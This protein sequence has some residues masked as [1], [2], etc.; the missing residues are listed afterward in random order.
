M[1]FGFSWR[2]K[3]T[4][5]ASKE[6]VDQE[7]DDRDEE[8]AKRSKLAYETTRKREFKERWKKDFP[9]VMYDAALEH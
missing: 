7:R 8:P 5:L 2:G 1:D 3:E 4:T 9:W 6:E